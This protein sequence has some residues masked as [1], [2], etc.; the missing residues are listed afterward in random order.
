M[1][2]QFMPKSEPYV[3]PYPP[4]SE[5]ISTS[6]GQK[7]RG[8]MIPSK[9]DG[10]DYSGIGK[11]LQ[12]VTPVRKNRK[13][14]VTHV[15]GIPIDKSKFTEADSHVYAIGHATQEVEDLNNMSEEMYGQGVEVSAEEH[16]MQHLYANGDISED[17]Y[18]EYLQLCTEEES[19]DSSDSN[20]F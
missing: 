13:K 2:S 4:I 17:Q 9:H 20:V 12:P 11:E 5:G 16:H 6:D 1:S 15:R 18:V 19:Y 7:Q 3:H 14:Q 8:R 10:I